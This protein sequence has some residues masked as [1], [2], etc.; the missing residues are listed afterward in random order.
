[1]KERAFLLGECCAA[2]YAAQNVTE[3]W[4]AQLGLQARRMQQVQEHA[5]RLRRAF[6]RPYQPCRPP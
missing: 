6:H 2:D 4:Q 5:Q 1:M 3:R